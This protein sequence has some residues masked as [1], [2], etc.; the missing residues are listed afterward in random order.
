MFINVSYTQQ[1]KST[2]RNQVY[3]PAYIHS[4]FLF[5]LMSSP[6]IIPGFK[7]DLVTPDHADFD[8]LIQRCAKSTVKRPLIVACVK[9]EEGVQL[10]IRFA[11][12]HAITGQPANKNVA[13]NVGGGILFV[14]IDLP[15]LTPDVI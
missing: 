12:L 2:Q 9:D 13:L 10:A 7:G 11:K 3:L 8:A 15:L 4:Y 14:H 1:G 5:R 6:A